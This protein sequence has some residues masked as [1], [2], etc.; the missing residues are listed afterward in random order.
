LFQ[1]R[2]RQIRFADP[3]TSEGRGRTELE[4]RV[5]LVVLLLL[6]CAEEGRGCAVFVFHICVVASL[7]VVVLGTSRMLMCFG[8]KE[9]LLQLSTSAGR[10]HENTK[11]KWRI[12]S[13][14][15]PSNN[16]SIIS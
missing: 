7:L 12:I 2:L 4:K 5:E 10:H 8:V 9:L 11:R 6:E 15:M 3:R 1:K 13:Y 14:D 16:Q